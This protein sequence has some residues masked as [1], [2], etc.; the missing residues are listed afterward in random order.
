MT[1]KD[2]ELK[3][4]LIKAGR[5]AKSSYEDFCDLI[6]DEIYRL[7][8][9]IYQ[10]EKASV[11]AVKRIL[12]EMYN[13]AGEYNGSENVHIWAARRATVELYRMYCAG[14][15]EL[16][17]LDADEA[18]YEY[19]RVEED[20]EL[21]ACSA[22]YN[23]IFTNKNKAA[24]LRSV[25]ENFTEGQI[26]LYELF[27][28]EKCSIEEMED[29]LETDSSIISRELLIIRN[30]LLY[31]SRPVFDKNGRESQSSTA[32]EA[33]LDMEEVSPEDRN[34]HGKRLPGPE[35]L[36]KAL[37]IA[38]PA[39]AIL[40]L[41]VII[42]F[43]NQEKKTRTPGNGNHVTVST[44]TTAGTQ[45]RTETTGKAPE[46]TAAET[47]TTA[48]E[49]A[50]NNRTTK[51]N[52]NETPGKTQPSVT[53]PGSSTDGAAGTVEEN[54]T[55]GETGTSEENTTGSESSTG[56]SEADSTAPT[57]G[58]TDTEPS[59]EQTVSPPEGNPS[60]GEEAEP[61]L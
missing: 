11:N 20:S 60:G 24:K 28:Y 30:M 3:S 54:T 41:A 59:T 57:E 5:G 58:N 37:S 33:M 46:T 39:I 12:A 6:F 56:E 7:A 10:E 16:F 22:Q 2:E 55:D 1:E 53:E 50:G 25:F 14:Q 29:L 32:G 31:G 17:P 44:Q 43:V 15:K 52:K 4:L 42:V 35:W 49:A 38:M 18:D 61:E 34:I 40:L 47:K 45:G 21:M 13:H 26:I 27:C 36:V 19:D 8:V 48:A 9:L 23:Q 51:E